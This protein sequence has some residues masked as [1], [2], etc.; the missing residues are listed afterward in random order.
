MANMDTA[1]LAL[2]NAIRPLCDG[3]VCVYG[4]RKQSMPDREEMVAQQCLKI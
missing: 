3:R 2:R 1:L 4:G